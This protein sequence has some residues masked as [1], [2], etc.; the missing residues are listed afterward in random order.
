MRKITSGF[1]IIELLV[2]VIVIG[3]L[4][5]ISLISFNRYQANSR[6]SQRASRVTIL[7]EAL[8]KYYDKNGEYPSCAAMMASASTLTTTTLPGLQPSVLLTPQADSSLT[9]SITQCSS[10][11]TDTG[12]DSFAYIGDGTTP[13]ATS[14]CLQYSL[15]YVEEGSDTVKTITSRRTANILTSGDIADAAA[16]TYS[17]SQINLTWSTISGATSYQIE[18]LASA[19]VP[20]DAAFTASTIPDVTTMTNSGSVTG[21]SLN[22]KYYFR[23]RP[24]GAS[25][26]G[27]WSN[28]PFATTY[29][30]DTPT[31]VCVADPAAP[32]TQLKVT[33]N[34]VANA[35]SYNLQYS[36]SSSMSSPTL[37][38]GATSPYVLASLAAGTTRYFQVQ[39]IASGL[40]SGWSTYCQATTQVPVPTGLAITAVG[41]TTSTASWSTVSVA[42]SYELDRALNSTF[43]SSLVTTTT[44]SISNSVTGLTQGKIYYYRVRAL[45]GTVPSANSATVTAATT[46]VTTPTGV[47]WTSSQAAY[48]GSN[49]MTSPGAGTYYA[50]SAVAS[51]TCA[52]GTTFKFN[53]HGWYHNTSYTWTSDDGTHNGSTSGTTWYGVQPVNGYQYS[54]S[55]TAYCEGTNAS[56]SNVTLSEIVRNQ[57]Y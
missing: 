44:T 22:T 13:C 30:L 2:V 34:T 47:S 39:S 41:T 4:S 31:P 42:T 57:Y 10:L 1:T 50:V 3:I 46:T 6:D 45:V 17:F 20:S 33:F 48:S 38:T 35:T 25:G 36:S 21:L 5:T 37:I 52:T 7:A 11:A 19:S 51:G 27:N 28:T 8:E 53:I 14:G 16:T 18:S 23:V 15:Q 24:I 54:F 32:S 40:S 12:V 43:T 49:W 9:N 26:V 29:S 55:G 56:S